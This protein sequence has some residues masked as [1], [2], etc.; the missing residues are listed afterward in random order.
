MS[1]T[2]GRKGFGEDNAVVKASDAAEAARLAPEKEG[3]LPLVV[4]E[5]TWATGLAAATPTRASRIP[6][7]V[8]GLLIIVGLSVAL[9]GVVGLYRQ[10]P[11][12][13]WVMNT[14]G[15]EP[16]GGSKNPIAIP[17]P[18]PDPA[19]A[20]SPQTI[21]AL[22]RLIPSSKVV[23][24]APASGVRDARI[25]ELK[26]AEGDTVEAGQVLAVLD[27][28]ARLASI[29]AYSRTM[30]A[31]REALVEQTRSSVRASLDEARAS[32]AR[33]EAA[34]TRARQE[35]SRT[36]RLFKKNIVARA[37]YDTKFAALQE[38]KKEVERQKATVS[39]FAAQDIAKQPDVLAALSNV[40]TAK[41]ELARAEQD[42]EQAYVRAPISGTVLEIH[43]LAG[44][45]PG[46]AGVL[47]LGNVR[48]MTAE[49]EVY[50]SQIGR[51][52]VGAPVTLAATALP[53]DLR[54][55]VARI[56]LRVKRQSAIGQD[57]AANTDA[58]VIEVVVALDDMSSKVASRFTDLQVEARIATGSES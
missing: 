36:E 11:G 43:S 1:T 15:L 49:V 50:Q 48:Q 31:A 51:V 55:Q 26:V 38:A 57:P 27:N 56:G 45:K 33:A 37:A 7:K 58:R 53:D 3:T 8:A 12:L 47:E 21:I 35:F 30:I 39:R 52:S 19:V 14:L 28:Q 4:V 5:R 22:G 6:I 16:G 20:P 18:R 17:A 23:T 29:V 32:L 40:E 34:A 9:G 10:P 25:A 24:V 2:P 54:G 41:A 42:L 46:D 13:Q 44:E